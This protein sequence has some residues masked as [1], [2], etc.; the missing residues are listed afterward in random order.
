MKKALKR[1]LLSLTAGA[2][3]AALMSAA[4]A[5]AEPVFGDTAG[6]WA[7][8]EINKWSGYGIIEGSEGSFEPDKEITRAETAAIINRIMNYQQTA[9]NTFIDL[10]DGWY[11]EA[12]LKTAADN[13]LMGYDGYVRPLDAV[14]REEAFVMLARAL[15]ISPSGGG[16]PFTDNADISDW[17]AGYISAMTE[18]GYVSGFEDGSFL[19]SAHMTKAYAVKLVDNIIK[20]F[21]NKAGTYTDTTDGLVVVN[22]PGV[23]LKNMQIKE[24]LVTQGVGDSHVT[25]QGSTKVEAEPIVLSGSVNNEG[26]GGIIGGGNNNN[27]NNNNGSTG[28]GGNTGGGSGGTAVIVAPNSSIIVNSDYAGKEGTVVVNRRR[29]TYGTN[30]FGSLSEAVVQAG[31]LEEKVTISL[32]GDITLENTVEISVPDIVFDGRGFTITV[33]PSEDFKKDGLQFIGSENAEIK[34]L[35]LSMSEAENGWKGSYGIQLYKSNAKLSDISISGADAGLLING[36]DI[37]VNGALDVSGNEFGGIEMSKGYAVEANPALKGDISNIANTTEETGKPTIWIDNSDSVPASMDIT[38]MFEKELIVNGK[39]QRHF[40]LNEDNVPEDSSVAVTENFDGLMDAAANEDVQL[41]KLA[42]DIDAGEALTL[43]HSV[44]IDGQGNTLTVDSSSRNAIVINTIANTRSD[45]EIVISNINIKFSGEAPADWRSMYGINIYRAPNVRLKNVSIS[46]GNAAVLV[47]GSTVTL[48]GVVDVTGNTF[49]GIELSKG[50]DV[51]EQP[52]I[53]GS[54]SN[55]KNDSETTDKPTVWTDGQDVGADRVN[56]TGLSVVENAKT[57]QN[58]FF[59][60]SKNAAVTANDAESLKNALSNAN[61]GTVILGTDIALNETLNI[62]RSVTLDGRGNAITAPHSAKKI[63]VVNLASDAD[64]AELKDINFAFDAAAP[65]DWQSAYAVQVYKSK[66]VVLN[67]IS[68]KNGNA[69]ILV[70]GSEVTLNGTIDVSDNSFGGIEASMGIGVDMQ[71]SVNAESCTLVNT[72]ETAGKPTIWID[73]ADFSSV[74]A[75]GMTQYNYTGDGKN[76]MHFYLS[77]AN[78]PAAY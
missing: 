9:E 40:Y 2:A 15:R 6:H 47:N 49:G 20:G 3:A 41:I 66:N 18:K 5:Y 39:M 29:Y 42:G 17:A 77:E 23:V 33:T 27:N 57:N 61:I 30:A 8:A 50:V 16:T 75:G 10:N 14:T 59:I 36:S 31:L 74:L 78:V 73:N 46:N 71:P 45:S 54:V 58:H 48:D 7:E 21:Y 62:N 26:S 51:T 25:L 70:N 24:L 22:T 76:Q 34:N 43:T 64:S 65:V 32:T 1:C 38:G 68:A 60:N 55:L 56:I 19:P 37:S 13:V 44:S 28:G 11:K 12:V 52:Y 69:G 53:S 63:A 72:T 35:K 4:F 67:N